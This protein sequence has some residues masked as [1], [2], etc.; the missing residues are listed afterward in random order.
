MSQRWAVTC[1]AC[2]GT[3]FV[4][5]G[6]LPRPNDVVT[7]ARCEHLDGSPLVADQLKCDSCGADFALT[8]VAPS[9]E[10]KLLAEP[11]V[12]TNHDPQDAPFGAQADPR[13]I[14]SVRMALASATRPKARQ[15][16]RRASPRGSGGTSA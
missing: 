14:A 5:L 11:L 7:S 3:A 10:W 2:H 9:T 12:R 8:G 1:K 4:V 13:D 6:D 15:R 16:A